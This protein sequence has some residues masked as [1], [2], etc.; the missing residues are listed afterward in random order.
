ALIGYSLLLISCRSQPLAT[1][2]PR[3]AVTNTATA[4]PSAS[5][6]TS[7]PEPSFEPANTS[8]PTPAPLQ[9]P[10]QPIT[11][12]NASAI[13]EISR[14]GLGSVQRIQTLNSRDGEFLV[15]TPLGVYLY[16]SV[17]PQ[18][19]AFIPDAAEFTL[20]PDENLLAVSLKN[21]NVQIWNMDP[22]SLAETFTHSFP[23]DVT[24]KIKERKL[25]PFYVGGMA[26]SPDSSEIAIGYADGSVELYRLGEPAPYA[27]LRHDAFA[28]LEG[29]IGLIYQLGYSP[30]GKTL[31]IFKLAS[32]INS[33]RLTF[34]SLPE[35]E[36]MAVSEAGR[37]Y[38]F[39]ASGYLPDNQ[40]LLVFSRDGSY[41]SLTLWNILTGTKLG[42]FDT[43][44][45]KIDSAELVPN[46]MELTMYGS[47]AQESYFR[48]V[49]VLPEGKLLENEKIDQL[50]ENKDWASL[51]DLLFEKG[52]Y[53]NSWSDE[54]LGDVQVAALEGGGFRL[55][56]ESDW[57]MFPGGTISPLT[58]PQDTSSLFYD[59]EGHYVA[60]CTPGN[61]NFLDAEGF[62]VV[63]LAF[64]TNC[65][66]V[67]ISHQRR[68]AAIWY[69]ESMYIA[70][71][72][73][74]TFSKL[75]FDRRWRTTTIAAGFSHDEK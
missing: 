7:S 18:M 1:A 9:W 41:F 22:I 44:L 11:K 75:S 57:L 66:G 14:W 25:L 55:L 5:P 47:D 61:L 4:H 2:E 40:T 23:E 70:N 8:V 48:Q 31:T 56:R 26:F 39:A 63:E 58:I 21:G 15:L 64:I 19:L 28:L 59:P 62:F 54:E 30:D 38:D 32:S 67:T 52:H 35:A 16:Q 6:I 73:A 3:I 27:A 50:P 65:D 29:D 46:G 10:F 60:W 20:S 45:A 43:G 72:E 33:N 42:K 74:G 24:S 68:Y 71:L 53:Y 34:W 49:R 69:G 13:R 36:L 12:D 51:R 17:S 37:F